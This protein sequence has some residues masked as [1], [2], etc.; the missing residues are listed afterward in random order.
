MS[1]THNST[2][3]KPA[4]SEAATQ[5]LKPSK[6]DS[7]YAKYPLGLI[8]NTSLA[9]NLVAELEGAIRTKAATVVKRYVRLRQRLECSFWSNL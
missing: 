8:R 2:P 5:V 3:Q 9:P 1:S 6:I 7:V 4:V